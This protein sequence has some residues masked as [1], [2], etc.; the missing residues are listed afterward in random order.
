MRVALKNIQYFLE[1][2]FVYVMYSYVDILREE[3]I[4]IP[5]KWNTVVD[6]NCLN[7][8]MSNI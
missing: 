3:K 6:Q 5:N 2:S 1:P 8:V 7:E 4:V